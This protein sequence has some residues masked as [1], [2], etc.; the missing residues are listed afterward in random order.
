MKALL[1]VRLVLLGAF[2]VAGALGGAATAS[3][4]TIVNVLAGYPTAEAF[5]LSQAA[6]LPPGAFQFRITSRGKALHT[7]EICTAP[8]AKATADSCRGI[9]TRTLRGGQSATLTVH[10]AKPGLYEYLSTVK[11]QAAKGMK[12]LIGVGVS[13]TGAPPPAGS[14][15]GGGT[16]TVCTGHCVPSSTCSGRCTPATTTTGG[17]PPAVESLVGDPNA[18]A[19]LFAS[20]CGTCHALAAAHTKGGTGPDLDEYAPGQTVIVNYV[21]NGSDAMPAFGGTLTGGEINDIAAY[22]YRSTH[23]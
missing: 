4:P 20:N 3:S 14:T 22:V 10:L 9:T 17:K 23:A 2:V 1:R 15:A 21:N 11:G 5:T 8:T 12:G 7:F 13:L 16:S 19:N 6:Y 18:G